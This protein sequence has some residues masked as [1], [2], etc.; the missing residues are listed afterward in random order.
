MPL[1]GSCLC[2]AVRYEIR[3]AID[4]VYNC[5]C[6]N[7]RKAQGAPFVTVGRVRR[8]IFA[9]TRGE[10]EISVYPSSERV[11]RHFCRGCG[12]ALFS[13]L[14]TRPQYVHVRLGT[15]DDDPGGRPLFHMFVAS[16]APWIEIDDGLPRHDRFPDV[17]E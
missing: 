9:I 10:G 12:A 17:A 3:G 7:C 13:E 1:H 14:T 16:K 4:G 6:E 2:G 5:H 11:K 15:L 8:E